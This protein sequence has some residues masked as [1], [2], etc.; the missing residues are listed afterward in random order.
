MVE[1]AFNFL[2]QM[3]ASLPDP[4][5]P[6]TLAS[7]NYSVHSDLAGYLSPESSLEKTIAMHS[8]HK[9]ANNFSLGYCPLESKELLPK[10][11]LSNN[12]NLLP[13][14]QVH[15]LSAEGVC[16]RQL[17]NSNPL[18]AK[19]YCSTDEPEPWDL[20]KLN[21]QASFICL[22]AKVNALV[23]IT[24]VVLSSPSSDQLAPLARI[25]GLSAA[26][27][28][29]L[30]TAAE[31]CDLLTAATTP[32]VSPTEDDSGI[33]MDK[34]VASPEAEYKMQLPIVHGE[35][36]VIEKQPPASVTSSTHA[37]DLSTK[38]CIVV[39]SECLD[40]F[41]RS[42]LAS[43]M[44]T[45]REDTIDSEDLNGDHAGSKGTAL[46]LPGDISCKYLSSTNSVSFPDDISTEVVELHNVIVNSSNDSLQTSSLINHVD[47]NQSAI[48]SLDLQ[49]RDNDIKTIVP[50]S[51]SISYSGNNIQNNTIQNSSQPSTKEPKLYTSSSAM[52]RGQPQL[53]CNGKNSSNHSS[54]TRTDNCGKGKTVIV[55][56]PTV[57]PPPVS[58]LATIVPSI[59][60]L[61]GAVDG[62]VRT[63]R[64]VHSLH[65][66]QLPTDAVHQTHGLQYRR[67]VCFA[68]AVSR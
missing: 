41:G 30:L 34:P 15:A 12:C 18:E 28:C 64:L 35:H 21:L 22:S 31:S 53:Q 55:A 49:S 60:K 29:D 13:N 8:P 14:S 56:P 33:S 54:P 25:D 61:R 5:Q 66:L 9:D 63:A 39:A 48:T 1:N 4:S 23:N 57:A 59:I 51:L 17:E 40:H 11:L 43:I 20:I 27:S 45:S 37:R 38:E 36:R 3:K 67:D 46:K 2:E 6:L 68:Q 10:Q 62:A 24:P 32:D 19:Y 26:G 16:K 42:K 7:R 50:P 47:E 65:R 58:P 44:E 52:S